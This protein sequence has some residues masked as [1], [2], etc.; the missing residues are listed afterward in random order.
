MMPVTP[1]TAAISGEIRYRAAKPS[2]I[3]ETMAVAAA[4]RVPTAVST[5]PIT[6]GTSTI[7]SSRPRTRRSIRSSSQSSVP[8]Y[9]A[10]ANMAVTPTIRT[11]KSAGK[12]PVTSSVATSAATPSRNAAA[13]APSPRSNAGIRVAAKRPI[14]MKMD[15]VAI[16]SLLARNLAFRRR[17]NRFLVRGAARRSPSGPI[18]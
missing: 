15:R 13:R 10:T 2:A 1:R 6:N 3:G 16:Q 4:G 7:S 12:K 9:C 14:R 17:A 8:L 5:A 18:M 11:K